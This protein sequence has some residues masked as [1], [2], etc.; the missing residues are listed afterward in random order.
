ME[1]IAY[2]IDDDFHRVER[3]ATTAACCQHDRGIVQ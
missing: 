3:A 2:A 1:G